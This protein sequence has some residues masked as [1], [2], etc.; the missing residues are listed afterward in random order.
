MDIKKFLAASLAITAVFGG[1]FCNY[2]T[3]PLTNAA[4]GFLSWEDVNKEMA[5]GD[6]SFIINTKSQTATLAKYNGTDKEV[7]IPCE[8]DGTPVKIIQAGA[9]ANNDTMESVVIPSS[10]WDIA[11]FFNCSA[12]RSVTIENNPNYQTGIIRQSAFEGCNALEEITIPDC[13]ESVM[14]NAFADCTSLAEIN[15]PD[16]KMHVNKY[17]FYDTPWY[18]SLKADKDGFIRFKDSIIDVVGVAGELVIPDDVTEIP[19]F[20]CYKNND[21]TSV[22]IPKN[23]I[24]IGSGAFYGCENLETATIK[25][26]DCR[27][28]DNSVFINKLFESNE[29]PFNYEA[30]VEFLK[31]HP[32]DDELYDSIRKTVERYENDP[33]YKEYIDN[34][35]MTERKDF[36]ESA[37]NGNTRELFMPM[38]TFDGKLIGYKSSSAETYAEKNNSEFGY[39]AM[40]G[41]VNN[42]GVIDSIDASNIMKLYT[43][44]STS[45]ENPTEDELYIYDM[46]N[47]G[48]IDS[49]DASSVLAYYADEATD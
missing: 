30:M 21:I 46:N 18:K 1:S 14:E 23:V 31:D 22:V 9:F 20:L 17:T 12:L 41:D 27:F 5:I 45:S 2:S 13:F 6:F 29:D 42:D 39:A 19:A 8:A 37:G 25:N 44:L 28:M 7:V 16:H 33:F 36:T 3:T 35:K 24:S 11:G 4:S 10:V 47:D 38:G 49:V 15:F 48:I 34:Y 32:I 40:K 26:P 43:K